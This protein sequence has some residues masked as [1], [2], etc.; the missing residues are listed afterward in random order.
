MSVAPE[1]VLRIAQLAEIQVDDDVL[2]TLVVQM[3][4]IIDYVA[5]LNALPAGETTRPFLAGPDAIRFRPDEVKP[6]PLAVGPGKLAPAFKDG[7]FIVPRLGQFDARE[8][9]P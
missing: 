3:S 5:Q 9:E 4:R 6:W 2:P 7:F 1:D 8:P